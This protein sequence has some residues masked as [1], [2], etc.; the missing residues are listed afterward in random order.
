M[1]GILPNDQNNTFSKLLLKVL[2]STLPSNPTYFTLAHLMHNGL[3]PPPH[4]KICLLPAAGMTIPHVY[5]PHTTCIYSIYQVYILHIPCFYF[6]QHSWL[7]LSFY[8]RVASIDMGEYTSCINILIH[9]RP[10]ANHPDY[11]YEV[12]IVTFVVY[13]CFE[14]VLFFFSSF[15]FF[16]R[17]LHHHGYYRRVASIQRNMVYTKCKAL[18]IHK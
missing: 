14:I 16:T 6:F 7:L 2:K 15:T 9:C 13:Y 4:N 18:H 12:I 5:I 1:P 11:T 17:G 8:L 10:R 3:A